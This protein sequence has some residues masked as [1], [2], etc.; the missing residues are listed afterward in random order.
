MTLMPRDRNSSTSRP[1]LR[2]PRHGHEGQT[3]RPVSRPVDAEQV[4]LD[5]PPA[6]PRPL[7]LGLQ[8]ATA[9]PDNEPPSVLHVWNSGI[10]CASPVRIGRSV[11]CGR[12]TRCQKCKERRSCPEDNWT[13]NVATL[14]VMRTTSSPSIHQAQVRPRPDSARHSDKRPFGDLQ[15]PCHSGHCHFHHI[16][17]IERLCEVIMKG[18][19]NFP[20]GMNFD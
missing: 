4:A 8:C 15:C 17:S 2:G 3:W 13:M 16:Q 6:V 11:R 9:E 12:H 14:P 18:C 19:R 20:L 5:E 1:A 10:I 7:E